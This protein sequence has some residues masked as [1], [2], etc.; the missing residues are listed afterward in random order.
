MFNSVASSRTR[1]FARI[2]FGSLAVAFSTLPSGCALWIYDDE[3]CCSPPP[4]AEI[5]EPVYV[6]PAEPS[7][8][9]YAPT[10]YVSIY[11]DPY[12]RGQSSEKSGEDKTERTERGQDSGDA[13][14]VSGDDFPSFEEPA[15]PPESS[16]VSDFALTGTNVPEPTGS[17]ETIDA[18]DEFRP[19]PKRES[20]AEREKAEEKI[21]KNFAE[22]LRE[23][24][25]ERRGTS[26]KKRYLEPIQDASSELFDREE[27]EATKETDD[28]I[29]QT[30]T[31]EG[32]ETM[33]E[34]EE[35]KRELYD[36]EKDVPT[37]VDWSKYAI[38]VDNIRAWFGMG[39]DERAALEYM[40]QACEKQKE[41]TKTRDQKTLREAAKLYEKAADR[42]P[43]PALRPDYAKKHPFDAP[44]SGTLIEED[45][46]FFAGECWFFSREFTHALTCYR[47]LV[48]TY[49]S[50]IYKDVAMK[51]LYYI[52]CYWVECSEEASV[53]SVNVKDK[54]KPVFSTFKGAEKAFSAIFLNDASDNGLAPD[55]LFA[56]ANAYMR[57]GTKQG[58]GSFDS[59]ARYYK[60]L[61][62]FYPASK[63]AEDAS[64]LAMIALHKSY[65]GAFYDDAPLNEARALAETILKSGRGN[66][67]VIYE[68]LENIKEEQA[69]R[70]YAL[71]GYYEK[72]GSFASARSYYNRLVKEYPNTD[73]AVEAAR[74]YEEIESKPAEA[75]QLAW[76]RPVAPFLPKSKNE[77]FEEV[78]SAELS[79]IARRDETL[80]RIGTSEE[81]DSKTELTAEAPSDAKRY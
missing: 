24:K 5:V 64:R 40:R 22:W 45:G 6:V 33:L 42:W 32:L 39:P 27:R 17:Y 66:M 2:L 69:H 51:R 62:E 26:K 52:G 74:R 23:K 53:P 34:N 49:G 76:I 1:S 28:A 13:Y 71:G 29:I 68:E 46:L 11:P 75:D 59:A 19:K 7:V 73:Y 41:Y 44:K 54:D 56:L 36:W 35:S 65:Q 47:A 3:P 4:P 77:F 63:K 38:S 43:G 67:D 10:P 16:E 30:V 18:S 14:P 9:Y 31:L 79:K 21:E 15:I 58:D 37:P 80:D 8:Y 60:Q 70:L 48:S 20:L 61:Y 72:R 50:S 12:F 57:R 81:R 25:A 55:A 78:P